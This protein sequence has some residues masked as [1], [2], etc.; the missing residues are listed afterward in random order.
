MK[1]TKIHV[2]YDPIGKI[3]AVGRPMGSENEHII[4]LKTGDSHEPIVLDVSED[5]INALHETHRI[6]VKQRALVQKERD[7]TK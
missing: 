6:D 4:P 5:L 2:W 7:C 1:R 3:L